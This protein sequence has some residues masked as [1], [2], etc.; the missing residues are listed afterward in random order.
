MLRALYASEFLRAAAALG[1]GGIAFALGS[2]ALA[3]VL[4]P[5]EY[6]LVSLFIGIVAVCG[7]TGPLGLDLVVARRGLQ[8]NSSWRRA[9]LAA[10]AAVG[11]V[12]AAVTAV[13]Y[14]LAFPLLICVLLAT[15]A[16]GVVQACGAH[17]Q[18]QRQFPT[19]LWIRQFSNWALVPVALCSALLEFRTAIGPSALI[20]VAALAG[21]SVAWLQVARRE[22][23]GTPQPS[24]GKVLGEA[25]SLVTLESSSAVFLQLERLL[26]VPTVGISGLAL[27]GV[28]AALVGSPF[29]LLQQAAQFTLI[30]SLRAAS[31]TGKRVQLL[32]REIVLV[33]LVSAAGSVAIWI[34]APRIARWFLP[35]RYDLQPALVMAGLVSGVLKVFSAFAF[36]TVIALARERSLRVL[37]VLSWA[38]LGVSVAGAFAAIPWGLVGVLYGISLGWLIRAVSATWL[39]L[40]YLRRA[41]PAHEGV[42]RAPPPDQVARTSAQRSHDR[43]ER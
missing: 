35:G 28:L 37:G 1:V 25:L 36:A 21:A 6:G 27:F 2:L 22:G 7:F 39:A 26:L 4:P 18:G 12:T 38:S 14:H 32:R 42:Q 34:A 16:R 15:A 17:F 19:A 11:V 29:R 31:G 9:A 40:P 30:P 41:A 24:P 8:L 20:T 43:D 10:C 13:A 5:D 3:R 33:S 23:P